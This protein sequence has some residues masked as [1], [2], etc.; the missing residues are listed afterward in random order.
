MA[1]AIRP[2]R[3]TTPSATPTGLADGELAINIPDKK[4]YIGNSSGVGVLLVDGNIAAAQTS[5]SP[6]GSGILNISTTE[7][8]VDSTSLSNGIIGCDYFVSCNDNLNGR[9]RTTKLGFVANS[10]V[11]TYNEYSSLP[12]HDGFD[13]A[14]LSFD[15][16]GSDVRLR[17]TGD[18]TNVTVSFVKTIVGNNV[19]TGSVTSEVVKAFYVQ[20][21]RPSASGPWQWWKTEGGIIIDLIVN[22]GAP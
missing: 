3:S 22:D 19:T 15:I 12:T 16:S 9:M 4:I 21:T 5:P 11:V 2:K 18:S 17:A 14:S 13:V 8:T 7:V 10:T 6:L 1:V 20:D